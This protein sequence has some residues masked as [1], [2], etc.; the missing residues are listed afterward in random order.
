MDIG[1]ESFLL[2][3]TIRGILAQRLVRVICPHCR[4][5]DP[6]AAS[7]EEMA[8]FEIGPDVDLYRGKGCEKCT[9]TGYYGRTGVFE[10][11]TVDE[12]V[13]RLILRNADANELRKLAKEHGMKTLF[14]DGAQKIIKGITTVSEVF[15][16]TQEA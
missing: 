3:S 15:R 8:A 14:Q 13:R 11:L 16:V 6:S 2:S 12:D 10:L 4:E 9:N 7:R 1:V 5:K